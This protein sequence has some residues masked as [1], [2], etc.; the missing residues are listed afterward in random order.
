LIESEEIIQMIENRI[1][2]RR[3]EVRPDLFNQVYVEQIITELETLESVMAEISDMKK[4][5]ERVNKNKEQ[6]QQIIRK[7]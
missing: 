7:M 4:R 6:K 1:E 3:K 2:E 5:E